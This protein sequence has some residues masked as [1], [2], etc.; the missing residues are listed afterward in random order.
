MQA[1]RIRVSP[2]RAWPSRPMLQPTT[3][4][5][6]VSRPACTHSTTLAWYGLAITVKRVSTS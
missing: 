1:R 4:A 2:S 3:S 5:P 6:T